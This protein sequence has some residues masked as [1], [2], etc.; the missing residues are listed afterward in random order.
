MLPP[1]SSTSTWQFHAPQ[2]LGF[3]SSPLCGLGGGGVFIPATRQCATTMYL[4]PLA[5]N[6]VD[7]D[8]CASGR[9]TDGEATIEHESSD[10]VYHSV[11]FVAT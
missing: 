10:C 11:A 7:Q 4:S 2:F 1:S 9:K 8:A 3:F 6:S 5:S